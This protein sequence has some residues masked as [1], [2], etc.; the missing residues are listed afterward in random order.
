MEEVLSYCGYRCDLCP[1]Y[2]KNL[3]SDDDRKRVSRDW[4]KY[5]DHRE[6][7]DNVECRGCSA[8][9]RDGNP[10]CKVRPCAIEKGVKTCA[11]C[12]EFACEKIVKQMGAIEPIAEKHRDSMPAEDY[13]RYIA[14]Y[15]SRPRLQEI[16]RRQE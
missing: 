13:E 9:V 12:D 5:Y 16:K 6:E 11:E 4:V 15:L 3:K 10:N 7:P 8:G 1:A 2:H 14:P